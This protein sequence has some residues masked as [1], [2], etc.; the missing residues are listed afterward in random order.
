MACTRRTDGEHT[1]NHQ[2]RSLFIAVIIGASLTGCNGLNQPQSAPATTVVETVT[3]TPTESG[4]KS[5]GPATSTSSP[6]TRGTNIPNPTASEIATAT[7]TPGVTPTP[8]GSSTGSPAASAT[9]SSVTGSEIVAPTTGPDPSATPSPAD[10]PRLQPEQEAALTSELGQIN[11]ALAGDRAVDKA[12][13]VCED[14]LENE[15]SRAE[16]IERT[17]Q[18]FSTEAGPITAETAERIVEVVEGSSFCIRS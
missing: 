2:A 16:I 18:R 9:E 14:L 8:N 7:Y 15:K 10:V 3:V 11:P 17:K 1:V 4:S 5:S 13:N 12:V 6:G